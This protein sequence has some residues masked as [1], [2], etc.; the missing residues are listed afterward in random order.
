MQ[1]YLDLG[2]NLQPRSVALHD[3]HRSF[4]AAD[5]TA[6]MEAASKLFA[7]KWKD[8]LEKNHLP[9][10]YLL[11]EK[12]QSIV[13]L[14]ASNRRARDESSPN[15][16]YIDNSAEDDL[17]IDSKLYENLSMIIELS[18]KLTVASSNMNLSEKCNVSCKNTYSNLGIELFIAE[19]WKKVLLTRPGFFDV[20]IVSRPSTMK[21]V[22]KVLLDAYKSDK[23]A[24]VYN[25]EYLRCRRD[26]LLQE[27]YQSKNHGCFLVDIG[28]Y[29]LYC[30]VTTQDICPLN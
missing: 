1:P 24:V 10:P 20:V 23:F 3:E 17:L 15:I 30:H 9:N 18:M 16:L 7:N 2:C 8:D 14:K 5:A 27:M 29:W 28:F 11:Q 12:E 22:N 6:K 21:D 25:A 26:A 4:G 13:F 19:D